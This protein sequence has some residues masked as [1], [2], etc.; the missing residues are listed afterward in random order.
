MADDVDSV[1]DGEDD[2]DEHTRT[3]TPA[4]THTLTKRGNES[5]SWRERNCTKK[6]YRRHVIKERLKR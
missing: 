1:D 5:E 4:Q 3:D 6:V 2:D